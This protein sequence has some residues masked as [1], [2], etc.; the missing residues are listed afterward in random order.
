MPTV[1]KPCRGQRGRQ[2][3]GLLPRVMLPS[4]Q[5]PHPSHLRQQSLLL[6]PGAGR[7]RHARRA[8]AAAAA[9]GGGAPRAAAP[10]AAAPAHC[11]PGTGRPCPCTRRPHPHKPGGAAQHTAA[12]AAAAA[13]LRRA[14]PSI[15]AAA[16]AAPLHSPRPSRQHQAAA[17]LARR[18]H[19]P[20]R[21]QAGGRGSPPGHLVAPKT[22]GHAGCD[23]LWPPV[24]AGPVGIHGGL[25]GS[26]GRLDSRR[27]CSCRLRAWD[28]PEGRLPSR[29][30]PAAGLLR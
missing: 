5:R 11:C 16:A 29:G 21:Q 15:A 2:H 10:A 20:C 23:L 17:A 22:G 26:C 1:V 9:A 27:L 14:P 4:A 18:R 7:L 30:G 19:R 6:P 8:A 25:P 13:R 24:G 3:P 12:A 28:I